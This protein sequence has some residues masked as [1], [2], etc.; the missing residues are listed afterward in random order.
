[1]ASKIRRSI[2]L[3]SSTLSFPLPFLFGPYAASRILIRDLSTKLFAWQNRRPIQTK[4]NRINCKP[5]ERDLSSNDHDFRLKRMI[6]PM[7]I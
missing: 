5:I 3:S 1:M 7:N 2:E 6:V 4:K